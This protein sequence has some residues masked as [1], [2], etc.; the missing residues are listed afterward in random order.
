M[1]PSLPQL[2]TTTF[3]A[4]TVLAAS[5]RS[6]FF[7][8]P[9]GLTDARTGAV[10]LAY[11]RCPIPAVIAPNVSSFINCT[12]VLRSSPDHGA[13]WGG[14]LVLDATFPMGDGGVNAGLQLRSGRLLFQRNGH[15]SRE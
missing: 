3:G 2:F 1:P 11:V 10:W 12:Q 9:L 14:E 15:S 7:T 5:N 13:S 8:D 6:F 4:A